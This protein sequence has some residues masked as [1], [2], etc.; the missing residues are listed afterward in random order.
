M[1][2]RSK[3]GQKFSIRKNKEGIVTVRGGKYIE[4]I[5]VKNMTNWEQIEA[6]K[7][8]ILKMGLA[9]STK[10]DKQVRKELE[11]GTF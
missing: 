8:V 9:F 6:V 7:W 4:N 1:L 3:K 5:D 2:K 11:K 10:I